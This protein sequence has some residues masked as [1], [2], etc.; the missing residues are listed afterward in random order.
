MPPFTS[1]EYKADPF[2]VPRA[3]D[4]SPGSS[5]SPP[6]SPLLDWLPSLSTFKRPSSPPGS[7]TSSSSS[8]SPPSSPTA[9]AHPNKH[10]HL[11][12]T[13]F[14]SFLSRPLHSFETHY[15][16]SHAALAES[17][18]ESVERFPDASGATRTKPYLPD[19]RHSIQAVFY[20]DTDEV[21]VSGDLVAIAAG[22]RVEVWSARAG[23]VGW[24]Q[25]GAHGVASFLEGNTCTSLCWSQSGRYLWV[26][27]LSGELYE[28]DTAAFVSA[29]SPLSPFPCVA[30]RRDA[31][32]SGQPVV[33]ISR[34]G[35]DRMYTLDASGRLVVWLPDVPLGKLV[36]LH[37]RSRVVQLPPKAAWVAVLNGRVWAAW[38]E[39]QTADGG[40]KHAVLRVFHVEG[41]GPARMVGEKRWET[42]KGGV[43]LGKAMSACVV[44]SHPDYTFI[45][46][47]S[48]HISVWAA[49]GSK[50]IDVVKVSLQRIT[51]VV[52]PS[53]FLW[54][55][56]SN[57]YIDIIDVSA[58]TGFGWRVVKRFRAHYGDINT[59][60]LDSTS[61][62]TA[63]ALR[64]MSTGA[65]LKIKFW[66]GLLREDWL[67]KQMSTRTDSY[68]RFRPLK[69]GILTWNTDGKSPDLLQ[70]SGPVNASLLGSFLNSLD[71]PDLVVFNFQELV[72]LS[73]LTLAAR[74]VLFATKQHD[75]TGRYRHWHAVLA[76]AIKEHLGGQYR[77]MKEQKLVGLY[78]VVF[79]RQEIKAQI[80]DLATVR[81]K[82]GFDQ[83]YGNKGSIM[84]RLVID[85]SSFCFVNS[86]LAAG[87]THPAERERDLITILDGGAKFPR[88]AECTHLAYVGGGDGTEVA[89]CEM[90]FFAG[91]LNF[92]IDLPREQVLDTMAHSTSPRA[93][94]A[95]L[96]PHDELLQLKQHNPSFRLRAF[97]EAP[98][99][100]FPTYK[101]DHFS[102]QYD[103]SEKQ[104]VPA[105]CD[106]VLWRA[107]RKESVK[108]LSYGRFE[109]DMSDHRPV[110]AIFNVQVK[111]IDPV[112]A[113]RAYREVVHEWAKEQERLLQTARSYYPPEI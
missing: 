82:N 73:D 27:C 46:H 81:I 64:V 92:R 94:V 83:Q 74:T 96:L 67:V 9:S 5:F 59:L 26:G 66:D 98:I 31:H 23:M 102:A 107:E 84:L 56:K 86:H 17:E 12:T 22:Y 4:A 71:R 11:S 39:M 101:Y 62:W 91:D 53:R 113:D 61:L 88:P 69:L 25:V 43:A 41:P 76:Q 103:T 104:R 10:F 85:D 112:L 54:V 78:T 95:S 37:A 100:F 19:Q 35:R 89:D 15:R 16:A 72:D 60:Q 1:L 28:F 49:D 13:P 33:K 38:N 75:V 24:C 18:A 8:L 110:A 111:K 50:L 44:P 14:P 106:R 21:K 70:N 97:E 29:P 47:D 57:G 51:A 42:R 20:G 90:V 52:G 58:G 77:L 108:A 40:H 48:G 87:K 30:H 3:Y 36:S 45:G 55:G 105:W 109:A 7:P 80:R 93:A 6:S 63:S 32:P 65:D 68:S 34:V 2:P 99:C 79:A